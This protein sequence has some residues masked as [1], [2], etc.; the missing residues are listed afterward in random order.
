MVKEKQERSRPIACFR[1]RSFPA[2]VWQYTRS[3]N[4][5]VAVFSDRSIVAC[6]EG[7]HQRGLRKGE[8]VDRARAL[9]PEALYLLRTLELESAVWEK[10]LAEL[11]TVSPA[12]YSTEPGIAFLDVDLLAN[13][14][15]LTEDFQAQTGLAQGRAL[16]LFAAL[17]TRPGTLNTVHPED[18]RSFLHS[19]PL[20]LLLE[21]GFTEELI[22]KLRLFGFVTLGEVM[23]LIRR[24]LKAQFG[25]EGIRLFSLLHPDPNEAPVPLYQPPPAITESYSFDWPAT[26]P[27]EIEP[28]L[29]HLIE[30]AVGRLGHYHCG[31]LTLERESADSQAHIV[32]KLLKKPTAGLAKIW[33]AARKILPALLDG[34]YLTQ[35]NFQLGA[36]TVAQP[37]QLELLNRRKELDEALRPVLRRFPKSLLRVIITDADAYLPEEGFRTETWVADSDKK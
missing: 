30:R 14:Q 36:L 32:R 9:F 11:N 31:L 16:A 24:H 10:I 34:N 3:Q 12:I 1:I 20:D 25:E 35:L 22:T 18:S 15:G 29:R 26:E 33:T 37:V 4:E 27:R 2:W 21:I 13:L 7:L 17:R 5:E 8:N 19:F 23:I 6:T 28:V